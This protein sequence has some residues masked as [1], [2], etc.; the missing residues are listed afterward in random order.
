MPI[1]SSISSGL[2]P[3]CLQGSG[4]QVCRMPS[5]HRAPPGKRDLRVVLALRHLKLQ[6]ALRSEPAQA[7]QELGRLH[8]LVFRTFMSDYQVQ[9]RAGGTQAVGSAKMSSK[10][11]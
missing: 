8:P 4:F 3:S 6:A 1:Y 9:A 7:A 2:R 11:A 5:D 10:V